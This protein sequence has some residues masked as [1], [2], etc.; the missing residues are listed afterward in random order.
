MLECGFRSHMPA[1]ARPGLENTA[2]SVLCQIKTWPMRMH[3]P[4]EKLF[5][6]L[7]LEKGTNPR[8]SPARKRADFVKI[9]QTG[10]IFGKTDVQGAENVRLL[11]FSGGNA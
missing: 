4:I 3:G 1:M 11:Y 2:K 10:C 8:I 6:F 5:R 7:F 9:S